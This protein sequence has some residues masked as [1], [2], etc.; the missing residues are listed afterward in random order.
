MGCFFSG[1]YMSELHMYYLY[2]FQFAPARFPC[3]YFWN[4]SDRSSARN[5]RAFEKK[6]I[7]NFMD[8]TY[9]HIFLNFGVISCTNNDMV[10]RCFNCTVINVIQV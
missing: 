6:S 3:A 8:I 9:K 10:F 7:F 2:F 4:H 5:Y 1:H